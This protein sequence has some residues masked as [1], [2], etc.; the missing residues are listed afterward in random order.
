MASG[1]AVSGHEIADGAE[2][3]QRSPGP[4]PILPTWWRC[5]GG[6][7]P[8]GLAAA[9]ADED[10][11]DD[12]YRGE[13]DGIG[14]MAGEERAATQDGTDDGAEHPRGPDERSPG[15]GADTG[16]RLGRGRGWH[17][18]S[19][20]RRPLGAEKRTPVDVTPDEQIETEPSP[21]TVGRSDDV[22]ADDLLRRAALWDAA[23]RDR[24]ES[25]AADLL[26]PDFAPELVQPVRNVMNRQVWL[27]VL[28]DYVVTSGTSRSR[29]SRSTATS[30]RS[31]D[32]FGWRPRSW[33]RTAAACSSCR[34]SGGGSTGSGGCGGGTRRRSWPLRLRDRR[35]PD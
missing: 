9:G 16:G 35:P 28:A 29:S 10:E 23:V 13:R 17:D 2:H 31:S 33:A 11:A 8:T 34:T 5:G 22:E 32:G 1:A 12:A 6:D 27:E 7:G 21:V 30:G 14:G 4:R 3:D 18:G 15:G 24:D 19:V 20:S 25:A 26:A